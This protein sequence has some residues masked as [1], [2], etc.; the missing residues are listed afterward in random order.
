[1]TTTATKNWTAFGRWLE[2]DGKRMCKIEQGDIL[3]SGALSSPELDAMTQRVAGLLNGDEANERL[4]D[5]IEA[6]CDTCAAWTALNPSD[7]TKQLLD[8]I[9]RRVVEVN[10]LR[11]D[12]E[13]ESHCHG[14]GSGYYRC[15]DPGCP[16][17]VD[18]L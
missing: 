3:F 4:L 10:D 16:G 13:P 1:M 7:E 2:R 5:A 11:P 15:E 14:D 6:I 17:P 8:A 12:D 9:K 18:A